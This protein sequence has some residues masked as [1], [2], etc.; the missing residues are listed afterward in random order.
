MV[1]KA[2]SAGE[3]PRSSLTPFRSSFK[4]VNR[5]MAVFNDRYHLSITPLLDETVLLRFRFRFRLQPRN[6]VS[7][8]NG[9]D[10]NCGP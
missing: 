9:A 4:T 6:L 1:L 8:V 3:T 5:M 7:A 10:S 2:N